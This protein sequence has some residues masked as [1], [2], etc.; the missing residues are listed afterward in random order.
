MLVDSIP[1]IKALGEELANRVHRLRYRDHFRGEPD[2]AVDLTL[3]ELFESF[4]RDVEPPV[5]L[6]KP[7]VG[8]ADLIPEI[9]FRQ[10]DLVPNLS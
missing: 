2:L 8:S 7:P 3:L 5:R 1:K 9:L 4:V 6:V 10:A